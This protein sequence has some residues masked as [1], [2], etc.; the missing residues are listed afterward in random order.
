MME[1]MVQSL[2]DNIGV[3]TITASIDEIILFIAVIVAAAVTY[4]VF[5][6]TMFDAK[7]WKD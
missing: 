3:S 1:E 6:D 4:K 2:V 5:Q 7:L